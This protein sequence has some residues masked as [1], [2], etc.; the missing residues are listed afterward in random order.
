MPSVQDFVLNEGYAV[1]RPQGAMTIPAFLTMA[2][3]AMKEC[4]NAGANRMLVDIRQLTFPRLLTT[5]DRFELGNGFAAFW[6]RR[7]RVSFLCR[8]DQVDQEDHF[9]VLVARN[10]G[11]HSSVHEIEQE[12][13]DWLLG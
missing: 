1:Y 2:E 6:D 11:L 8:S 3:A 9:A 12:A 13:L 10:R 4:Q 5:I 7:I